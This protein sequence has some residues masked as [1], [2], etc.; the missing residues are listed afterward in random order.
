MADALSAA[1][2]V[3]DDGEKNLVSARIFRR[4]AEVFEELT[5]EFGP[6]LLPFRKSFVLALGTGAVVTEFVSAQIP[7]AAECRRALAELGG[8]LILYVTA[9]DGIV[10]SG[11]PAPPICF[12]TTTGAR[13]PAGSPLDAWVPTLLSEYIRRLDRL[14]RRQPR[15]RATADAAI[16]RMHAAELH[17]LSPA[18]VGRSTWWRK[19]VLPILML[20]L[21]GWIAADSFD[22]S[23]C[24]R[25]WIWL[26]RLGEFFGWVDDCVDYAEDLRLGQANRIDFRL[27]SIS[28][29]R[30]VRHIA[31]QGKRVLEQWDAANRASPLHSTFAVIV[32][33]W[34][35]NQ[36]ARADF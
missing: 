4:G 20:G 16:R 27:R 12:T 10:D 17:S 36:P 2:I 15:L 21:P 11:R 31:A 22:A 30:L 34:I 13:P 26:A 32:W 19:N 25:H 6:D 1:G 7:L 35:E 24:L 18:P 5:G 29:E 8:L 23:S 33:S 9:L 28:K 3:A 14:P